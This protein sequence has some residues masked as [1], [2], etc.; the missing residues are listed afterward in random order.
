MA[1]VPATV[2]GRINNRGVREKTAAIFGNP[3]RTRIRVRILLRRVTLAISRTRGGKETR[4]IERSAIASSVR[5]SVV[6]QRDLFS[7]PFLDCYR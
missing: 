1:G 7:V 2:I 5:L 6:V 4:Q 3:P